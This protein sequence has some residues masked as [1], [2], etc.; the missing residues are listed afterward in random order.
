MTLKQ[1]CQN[2]FDIA[3]VEGHTR[4]LALRQIFLKNIYVHSHS[5]HEK[6]ALFDKLIRQR[7]M[8]FFILQHYQTLSP[9]TFHHK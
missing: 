9:R 4:C 8:N 3:T 1:M 7:E 2:P 5:K 6:D